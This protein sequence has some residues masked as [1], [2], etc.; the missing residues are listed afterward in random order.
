MPWVTSPASV[1]CCCLE[2]ASSTCSARYGACGRSR[3][4][5]ASGHERRHLATSMSGSQRAHQRR[6]C[7]AERVPLK[8]QDICHGTTVALGVSMRTSIIV[9]LCVCL[10]WLWP[11]GQAEAARV[12]VLPVEGTNLSAEET[13]AIGALLAQSYETREKGNVITPAT[14]TKMI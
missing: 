4:A 1:A 12:A 6:F 11:A 13:A 9:G 3:V 5:T 7:A 10:A 2:P 8:S 14:I